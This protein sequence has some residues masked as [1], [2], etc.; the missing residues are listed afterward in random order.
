M[1]QGLTDQTNNAHLEVGGD[2]VSSTNP[3]NIIDS[4]RV[5]LQ[6]DETLN[7]SDKTFTVS[8]NQ[9]W[10]ILWVWVEYHG[11]PGLKAT[12]TE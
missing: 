1:R 11:P 5:G 12:S 4:W 9:E 6:S 7:D 10:Q 3:V 8:A 2:P